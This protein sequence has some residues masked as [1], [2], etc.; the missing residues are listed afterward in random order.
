[1][2]ADVVANEPLGTPGQAPPEG[3][4]AGADL[5]PAL[6]ALLA[7]VGGAGAWAT[8]ARGGPW[9]ASL[10]VAV[11]AGS[12]WLARR[13]D[14]SHPGDGVRRARAVLTLAA[15]AVAVG[16]HPGSAP[17]T[18][19]WLPAAVAVYAVL[20]PAREA[21]AVTLGALAVLTVLGAQVA[22]TGGHP[23]TAYAAAAICVL[24]AGLAGGTLRAVLDSTRLDSTRLAAAARGDV[25]A[26]DVPTADVPTA[27]VPVTDVPAPAA[28]PHGPDLAA[29][30]APLP[31]TAAATFLAM[32][33][34]GGRRGA[35]PAGVPDT[36]ALLEAIDRAQARSGV[37]GGRVGLLVV[38]LEGL[39]GLP[40]GIGH[41]A[42]QAAL[43]ALTRRA[44]AWLPASDV[45]VW[46]GGGRLAVLLEGVDA[47][48]CLVVGRRL[49]GLL[50][51]PVEA[52]QRVLSLPASVAV[53]LADDVHEPSAAL[54]RRAE[55]APLTAPS[56]LPAL[57]PAH[58]PDVARDA[59][60]D[61]L[62]PALAAGDVR[63]ALQPIVALGTLPRHDRVVAVEALA[64]WTRPDGTTVPPAR[65][66]PAARQA[67]LA[68]LLGAAVLAQGLDALLERRR[69][70]AA[71]LDL[72]VNIAPEQ[73]AGPAVA[74][75]FVQA[76]AARDLEPA[77]LTV[78]LP[79]AAP[80]QDPAA[81][82][83]LLAL[84]DAGVGVVLDN[85]GAAGLSLA[86]LRD[87]PLTGLK[88]DRSL[89]ADLGR[90]DRLV[91][92]TLR[93]ATRLGLACTAV[94]VETP[95]QLEAARA[96]GVD[97]AQG[98]LLGRPEGHA[99]TG[100]ATRQE[101]T[102]QVP[103]GTAGALSTT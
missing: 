59:L 65:F 48:T 70:G 37:V 80:L 29:L 19:A 102:E 53:T 67:G 86:A 18:L 58:A 25:P 101:R 31:A 15:A 10:A 8:G 97:R 103:A 42:A 94:G 56:D 50:G 84:R 54:L 96:L 74:A 12:A 81:V 100:I 89:V 14:P 57:A 5:E 22:S 9:S 28:S 44:R 3:R 35:A 23:P 45:I 21:T 7:A 83:T 91:V 87:L 6:L 73:L 2:D 30:S 52:G 68:D 64:R 82:A 88:L 79:A 26:A 1:M 95:E 60:A 32:P 11:L 76:L 69:D 90:D 24:A 62:W 41:S 93:L 16:A 77:A 43:D 34:D 40:A 27:D 92:A 98:H 71:G 78:E 75:G 4:T 85:F 47:Q 51:E 72:A 49:A 33:P 20:L 46:L 99:T 13:H 39:V 63:V 38:H 17:L 66:V 36:S 61:E 55:A